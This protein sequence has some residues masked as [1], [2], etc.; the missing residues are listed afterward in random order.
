[1]HNLSRK[2][3]FGFVMATLVMWTLGPVRQVS[4]VTAGD[5]VKSPNSDAVYYIAADGK[6]YV[7]PDAKT[8]FTWYSNFNAVQT[9]AV[10]VLDTYNDG[11]AVT[12]RPGT[13]LVTTVDTNKVYAVEP[14]GVIR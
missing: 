12:Y 9:V 5:L 4:A 13:R 7:F 6:K 10:S 2:F 11:G 8:Y 14:G 3:L 1:M